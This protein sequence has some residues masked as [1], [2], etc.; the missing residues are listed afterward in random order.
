M[1]IQF[2]PPAPVLQGFNVQGPAYVDPLQT[3]AEMQQLRTQ[4]MQQQ[5][6]S[7]QLEMQ[8]AKLASQ[9]AILQ[10]FVDAGK[11][12]ELPAAPA[13]AAQAPAPRVDYTP[14]APYTP[15]AAPTT[16]PTGTPGT[17]TT[18]TQFSPGSFLDRVYR[19]AARSG[20]VLPDDL[21]G[22]LEHRVKLMTDLATFD[23]KQRA[24]LN[25]DINSYR[26]LIAGVTDQ[27]S[28]DRANKAAQQRNLFR[29]GK[30]DPITQFTDTPHITAYSNSLIGLSELNAEL[31]EKAAREAQEAETAL[32]TT[33][34][35]KAEQEIAQAE[36]QQAIGELQTASDPKTG[37][38]SIA[39]T[40]AIMARYPKVK[41]PSPM[42]AA[43]LKEFIRSGVPIEKQPEYDIN[44]MKAKLG[45]MGGGDF[46]MYMAQYAKSKGI[47]VSEMPF[48]MYQAG[49]TQY[50]KDR[51]TPE[52]LLMAQM[53]LGMRGLEKERLG[54]QVANML[55]PAEIREFGVDLLDMKLSPA[56]VAMFRSRSDNP[57]P[58]ILLAAKE[59]ARKRGIPFDQGALEHKYKTWQKTEDEFATGKESD[60]IQSFENLMNHYGLLWKA[61]DA[62]FRNDIPALRSIAATLRQA[63]GGS[64]ETV[65]QTIVNFVA[66]EETKTFVPGGGSVEERA[67]RRAK[68]SPGKGQKQI[69]DNITTS[70]HLVDSQRQTLERKY[71]EGTFGKGSR[72]GTLFA[73]EALEARDLIMG[74]A[75]SGGAGHKKDDIVLYQGK[76]RK[77]LSVDPQTGKVRLDMSREY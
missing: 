57:F 26:G 38:P 39:D 35:T 7:Q 31:K 2:A 52:A 76:R 11:E 6:A 9:K 59:E 66:D 29:F 64:A 40:T 20:K 25:S 3:L 75:P 71:K 74:K 70:M 50:A 77:V 4:R 23:E 15:A 33:Q 43:S 44:Q 65:F 49:V 13:P 54:A 45:I 63:T 17:P 46:D 37:I 5:V 1:P 73:P 27:P 60:Q 56:N 48:P 12:E 53:L 36:K 18:G 47:P 24:A 69:T 28:L 51:Q 55:S 42:S 8:S 41:F 22:M 61:K 14:I 32:K 58:Q 62:L 68:Y 10:A 19:Y 34:K 72:I 16:P 67:E 30:F 21:T